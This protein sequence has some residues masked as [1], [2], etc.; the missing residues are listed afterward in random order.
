MRV[1]ATIVFAVFAIASHAGCNNAPGV[2]DCEKLLDHVLDLETQ[3]AG[4][5]TTDKTELA[6]QKKAVTNTI[7][8]EFMDA[9]LEKLPMRQ[10]KCGLSAKTMDELAVCDK[11]ES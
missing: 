9:C 3:A 11:S 7:G 10:V 5:A 6:K 2:A 8:K 1:L 4:A